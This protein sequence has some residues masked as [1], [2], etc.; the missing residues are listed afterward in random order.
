MGMFFCGS[1]ATVREQIG[2]AWRDMRVGHLL[3]ML[4][5]GTLPAELTE[6]NMRLF[7]GEVMP[8]LRQLSGGEGGA[9]RAA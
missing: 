3:A 6:R 4:Q 9:A 5:F 8:W 7:A 2:A 1:A